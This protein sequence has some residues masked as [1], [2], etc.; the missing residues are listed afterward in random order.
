MTSAIPYHLR[1]NKAIDRQIFFEILALLELPRKIQDYEY[2]S[3]GGPMLEDHHVLHNNFGLTKL[4]SIEVDSAI[5]SRQ[6]FNKNFK[7]VEC[8]KGRLG[9]F[10]EKFERSQETVFWLDYTNTDWA[11]QFNEIYS[12]LTKLLPHD[13]VKITLNAN[14]DSLKNSN[15]RTNF[16]EFKFRADSRFLNLNINENDIQTMDRM[17]STLSKILGTVVDAALED[18]SMYAFRPISIFRYIDNR[19]QMLTVTGLILEKDQEITQMLKDSHLNLK[20]HISNTWESVHEISVP[21]LTSKER[22]AIN[23]HL[24]DGDLDEIIKSLQFQL[25]SNKKKSEKMLKNY[26]KYYRYI[27]TFHKVYL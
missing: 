10:I 12:L 9:D 4:K 25:D 20:Q 1:T 26:V 23:Q 27:P 17:A 15:N 13:I 18:L 6:N 21:D 19:Q 7:C 22:A 3:L 11:E 5:F 2:I 14:P 24:P 16:E 8:T